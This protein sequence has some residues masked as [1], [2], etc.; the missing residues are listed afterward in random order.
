MRRM[1]IASQAHA[2]PVPRG[3]LILSAAVGSWVAL[4]ALLSGTGQLVALL[5]A[6]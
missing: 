1:T 3:L 4:A 6:I 2:F 5:T